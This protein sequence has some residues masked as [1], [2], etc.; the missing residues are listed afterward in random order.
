MREDERNSIHTVQ[1]R[2]RMFMFKSC[3]GSVLRRLNNGDMGKYISEIPKLDTTYTK[4]SP[5]STSYLQQSLHI[6]EY[7]L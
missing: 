7:I 4:F 3:F 6:S 1:I 2:A 5:V